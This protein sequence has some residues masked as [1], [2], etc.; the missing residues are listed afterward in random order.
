[1]KKVVDNI[2]LNELPDYLRAF[3]IQS[4]FNPSQPVDNDAGLRNELR[5]VVKDAMRRTVNAEAQAAEAEA[6]LKRHQSRQEGTKA[7]TSEHD[8]KTF[9][10]ETDRYK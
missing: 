5:E 9:V 8:F 2:N 10:R 1:M 7:D 6:D 4:I 3:V